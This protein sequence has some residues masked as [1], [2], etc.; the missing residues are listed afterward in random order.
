MVNYYHVLGLTE[1]A[2][3][4]EIKAAFK[5]LAVKYHP[6]KHPN[7]P[8]MEEKFK[9]INQAHQVLSD[10]YEKTRFDL[11]LKYQQFSH[12]PH[13]PHTYRPYSNQTHRRPPRPSY[14]PQ[15]MDARQNIIA[16]AYAFGI[17][18]L[19]AALVMSGVWVKQSIDEQKDQ[20]YLAERRATFEA[21]KG[22]FEAGNYLKA[23]D[24][25]L[26]FKFF[27]VEERDMREFR[28]TMVDQII[29]KGHKE[30]EN[31]K[32]QA[33]ITLYNLA[34]ELKPQ[35][36]YLGIKKRLVEAYKQ[37][38]EIEKAIAI[39]EDFLASDFDIIASL[40][41]LAEIH[42]DYLQNPDEAMENFQLAHRLAVKRYK[43]IYGEGYPILIRE[44]HLPQS[45][46]HLYSGLADMYLKIGNP[47]MAI[48]AADWNKY[49]WP[50]SV[51]A[52]ATSGFA[53]LELENSLRACE[54]FESA[55][56]RG[57]RGSPPLNCN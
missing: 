4:Q 2:S 16:T 29:E 53:Y 9:E 48:K 3:P 44:E 34:F 39:L 25:M 46:F 47:Q 15:R 45:H 18:F 17:T 5:R 24:T 7:R 36:P 33:A 35:L 40:V 52:Y 32:F 43:K 21:A 10:P 55:L 56:N 11:K 27:R 26:S 12:P 20:A 13:E 51:D 37:A 6:D 1:E 49:V 50:D 14:R 38:G 8:E 54:E 30:L 42:R 41:N 23:Y 31:N 22:E 19:F 28:D 57:W